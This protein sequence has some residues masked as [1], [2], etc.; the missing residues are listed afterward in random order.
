MCGRRRGQQA[1]SVPPQLSW[2]KGK[3]KVGGGL[4]RKQAG[5]ASRQAPQAGRRR[6]QAGAASKQAPSTAPSFNGGRRFPPL[7]PKW[8]QQHAKQNS[9]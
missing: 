6:K 5:S 7:I 4:L 3:P 9:A 8:L 1:V 2:L